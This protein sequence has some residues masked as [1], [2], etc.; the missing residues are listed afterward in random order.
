MG[1][2]AFI[3]F[4][5]VQPSFQNDYSNA[6]QWTTEAGTLVAVSGGVVTNGGAGN[7][8]DQRISFTGGIGLTLSDTEWYSEFDF[9]ATG[10]GVESGIPYY[11]SDTTTKPLG[12]LDMLGITFNNGMTLSSC[13]KDGAGSFTAG[14]ASSVLSVDTQYYLTLTRT[15]ATNLEFKVF[16]DVT[17]TTQLGSTLNQTIP[18]T[19]VGLDNLQHSSTD[20]GG[21]GSGQTVWNGDN[22]KVWNNVTSK[23]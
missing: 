7:N 11:F 19:I 1:G 18:S 14:T 16:T 4:G 13:F 8:S 5:E 2:N 6:G 21:T 10:T 3:S 15:S 22:I 20:N 17:R 23:P 9:L 12:T